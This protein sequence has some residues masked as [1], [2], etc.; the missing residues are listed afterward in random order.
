MGITF[1]LDACLLQTIFSLHK[2]LIDGLESRGLLMDY[3]DVFISCL[4]LILTA[5]IHC[6]RCK[7]C[8]AKFLPIDW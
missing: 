8:N 1:S 4:T 7:W 6:R 3:S 2:A 5:T